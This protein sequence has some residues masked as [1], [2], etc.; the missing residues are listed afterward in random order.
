MLKNIYQVLS[1]YDFFNAFITTGFFKIKTIWFEIYTVK[2]YSLKK[3]ATLLD[4]IS[5]S[6]AASILLSNL[7]DIT[8]ANMLH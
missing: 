8:T 3:Y 5:G 6:L 7:I 2:S 1:T 4:K